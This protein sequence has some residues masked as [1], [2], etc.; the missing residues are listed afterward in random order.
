MKLSDYQKE[1]I[2][3]ICRKVYIEQISCESAP[4]IIFD[5]IENECNYKERLRRNAKVL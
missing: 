2:Q 1:E 4:F 3:S 5:L